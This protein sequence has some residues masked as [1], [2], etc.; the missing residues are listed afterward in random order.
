MVLKNC[1]LKSQ[2]RLLRMPFVHSPFCHFICAHWKEK[3]TIISADFAPDMTTYM[4]LYNLKASPAA[5]KNKTLHLHRGLLSG[6][7][8][9]ITKFILNFYG[10]MIGEK[11]VIFLSCKTLSKTLK[12]WKNLLFMANSCTRW[13][14]LGLQIPLAVMFQACWNSIP[15]CD[16]TVLKKIAMI[17]SLTTFFVHVGTTKHTN[18]A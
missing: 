4:T 3:K 15:P 13:S 16:K 2:L 5:R 11:L 18:S 12:F 9:F 10:M 6:K 7:D 17:F 14:Y 8:S 1:A